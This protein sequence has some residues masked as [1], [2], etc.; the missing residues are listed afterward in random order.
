LQDIEGAIRAVAA[1]F[2]IR[3]SALTTYNPDLDQD[4]KTL[5]AG[6][7]IIELVAECA[8]TA[9]SPNWEAQ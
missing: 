7:R 8:S 2:R 3:A 1:R 4:E 6:L 9:S 5:R